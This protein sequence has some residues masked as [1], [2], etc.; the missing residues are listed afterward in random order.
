MT[1]NAADLTAHFDAKK[2]GLTSVQAKGEDHDK[3]II[4]D[5]QGGYYQIDN[6][7]HGQDAGL[8]QDQGA[9]FKSS[10]EADGRAAG[11]D[12]SSFNTAGDVQ[13]AIQA[14]AGGS[15]KEKE[16]I[17]SNK[18]DEAHEQQ[19]AEDKAYVKT[20]EDQLSSIGS[21]LYGSKKT[22]KKLANEFNDNYKLNLSKFLKPT[23]KDGS[24][25]ASKIQQEKEAVEGVEDLYVG[26]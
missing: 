2:Y 16:S 9:T 4:S 3:G 6:F 24:A 10:L 25:R 14:I 8:D 21:Q 17:I 18:D 5:G 15:K 1:M 11:F 23:N 19:I 12:P 26:K 7:K 22:K 13:G 20:F